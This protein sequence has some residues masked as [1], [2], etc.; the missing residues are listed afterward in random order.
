MISRISGPSELPYIRAMDQILEVGSLTDSVD[1]VD[2]CLY[3]SDFKLIITSDSGNN[4]IKTT[5]VAVFKVS[6]NTAKLC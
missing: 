3:S 1:L 4:R 5:F 2:Y 6:S